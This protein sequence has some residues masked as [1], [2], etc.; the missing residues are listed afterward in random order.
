MTATRMTSGNLSGSTTHLNCASHHTETMHSTA[1]PP[2]TQLKQ[3]IQTAPELRQSRAPRHQATTPCH[4]QT[5]P[6]AAIPDGA[7]VQ[8][9]G[10]QGRDRRHPLNF[11]GDPE[12]GIASAATS[13]SRTASTLSSIAASNT[14][15]S[16]LRG[17]RPRGNRQHRL[18]RIQQIKGSHS[19]PAQSCRVAP[20]HHQS[21]KTREPP[22]NVQ[23]A[24]RI[25]TGKIAGDEPI[26][27][28]PQQCAADRPN[29]HQKNIR[30]RRAGPP[31]Q[32]ANPRACPDSKC[33]PPVLSR[34]P[35]EPR[36]RHPAN[37]R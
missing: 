18:L 11:P 6:A 4:L 10:C 15:A 23:K 27:L 2:K 1:V 21:L 9:A 34:R 26:H 14:S 17:V 7:Q 5:P 35:T 22:L 32:A 13:A 37:S 24:I 28:F 19:R 3:M 12:I 36:R 16:P 25:D 20:F 31:H 8:L 33:E 30:L 29:N